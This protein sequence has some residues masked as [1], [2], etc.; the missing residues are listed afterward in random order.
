[1]TRP[2]GQWNA[3]ARTRARRLVGALLAPL[4]LATALVGPPAGAAQAHRV[5]P[6][7]HLAVAAAEGSWCVDHGA[8][9]GAWTGGPADLP[10]CGPGPAY[11]GTLAYVDLPGPRG[12]MG[13]YYNATPGFQCVE[14]A[15]RYLAVADGLAPVEA[16]GSTLAENY[17]A[18]YPA[19][20]LTV[21]GSP[22][23]VGHPPVAGDAISFSLVPSFNDPTYGHV[24]VVVHSAVDRATGD[25][26]VIIAQENVSP[27]DYRM[28]LRLHDWR[29]YDPAEPAD[30]ALQY[31]YAEWFHPLHPPAAGQ[32]G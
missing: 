11:G 12:S 8:Q 21:N 26:T 9:V 20:R 32:A 24:A 27:T 10:V 13:R 17:H 14:L 2:H 18:A 1:M 5:R 30:A 28:V 4:T 22:G 15:E 31:P 23:A 6:R 3:R 16:E 19:S 25:G 7:A 29:L